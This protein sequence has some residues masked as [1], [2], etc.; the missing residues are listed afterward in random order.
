LT[1]SG[2][3]TLTIASLTPGG[4]NPSD[5]VRGGT[6]A[7]NTAL[8]GGQSCTLQY[9]FAPAATGNRSATLAIGTGAGAVSLSMSG[10]GR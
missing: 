8:A 2:G 1:N 9:T 5:F 3:G 6:C 10:R 7:I 4:A